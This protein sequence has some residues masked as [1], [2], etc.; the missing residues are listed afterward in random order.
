MRMRLI[1]AIWCGE[2]NKDSAQSYCQSSTRYLNKSDLHDFLA[3]V[4]KMCFIAEAPNSI[5]GKT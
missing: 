5:R 2:E 1:Y 4:I 3:A